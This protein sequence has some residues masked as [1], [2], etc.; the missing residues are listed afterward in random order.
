MA[1]TSKI[2]TVINLLA[3]IAPLLTA[4][5]VFPGQILGANEPPLHYTAPVTMKGG[6]GS[7]YLEIAVDTLHYHRENA[8][9]FTSVDVHA[10]FQLPFAV[11]DEVTKV[12]FVGKNI[13]LSGEKGTSNIMLDTHGKDYEKYPIIEKKA[14]LVLNKE[15]FVSIDC[16]GF[17]EMRLVG[18]FEFDPKTI[19]PA[20]TTKGDT[21]M[22]AAFD[23]TVADLE[24]IVIETGFKR[25]FK[26]KGTGD[27][28]YTV[29]GV[30]ADM[31]TVRNAD[32]FSFPKGYVQPFEKED[33]D[34]WT[35][36]ALK[37]LKVD[38]KD[39]IPFLDSLAAYNMLIDETGFS[40]WFSAGFS[41]SNN[42]AP[43]DVDQT[44][45]MKTNEKEEGQ[46]SSFIDAKLRKIAVGI[47]SNKV[48]GGELDGSLK[49]MGLKKENTEPLSVTLKGSIYTDEKSNL[50][51]SFKSTFDKS[52]TYQ[53]PVCEKASITIGAGTSVEYRKRISADSTH[54]LKGFYFNLCGSADFKSSLVELEGLKFQNLQFSTTKPYFGGGT[55]SL[56]SLKPMSLGGL[57]IGL[58][59]LSAGYD[60]ASMV[61]QLHA[62]AMLQLISDGNGAG[63]KAKFHLL[64]D[65]K[66]NWKILGLHVDS[67]AVNVDFS[68]FHLNG[69]IAIYKDD[70]VFGNGFEG[71]LTLSIEAININVA[72]AAKFGRTSYNSKNDKSYRYWYAYAQV[73]LPSGVM[74]FPP[75]VMLQ[76]VSLAVYSKMAYTQDHANFELNRVY[77]PNK[78][79]AFGFIGGIGVCVPTDNLIT[80]KV[81]LGM[82]FS[83][84]GGIKFVRLD[85]AVYML[86]SNQKNSMI[87]GTLACYYDFEN[88]ILDM[89]ADVRADLKGVITGNAFMNLHTDPDQWYFNLGTIDKPSNLKFAGIAHAKSYFMMGDNVPAFLPPLDKKITEQFNVVQS[90]AT[91]NDNS[92]MFSTGSGFAF[93]LAMALDCGLNKFI[94]ANVTLMGGTDALVVRLPSEICG[95]TKY[96]GKGRAY[97]YLDMDAGVS[98]R[99]K[100]FCIL[101]VSALASLEAEFPKPY[102]VEGK[103]CF[104]YRVLG[105]LVKGNANT[106][107]KA[108]SRCNQFNGVTNYEVTEAQFDFSG[109]EDEWEDAANKLDSATD[110]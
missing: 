95:S 35:G 100:K 110:E 105:G 92:K 73:G 67:I 49:V 101:G 83:A 4:L 52:Q 74:I 25:P 104:T 1:K 108:G 11:S 23:I 109:Y 70:A 106:K 8:G 57:S 20:D 51:Y 56:T 30:V 47:I 66:N 93:G 87:N 31:S 89:S 32:G 86:A 17:K 39:E 50:S 78:D 37:T 80:A 63:V 12:G 54:Y 76:S 46:G 85:G 91:A 62:G 26:V 55:F 59:N 71:N 43:T 65:V 3:R 9:G 29:T 88:D 15:S 99:R 33:A 69:A 77:V 64:S 45:A 72:A 98:V 13:V 34:Y 97:V 40:G 5:L 61:A 27:I 84:S 36:F 38:L 60:T 19:F 68:A 107:F 14:W 53:L 21:T 58:T 42:P 48:I 16:N 79:V 94:Y 18:E 22:K 75:A 90:E 102:Y 103:V 41:Y 10:D 7:T 28:T 2:T 44:I 96:R 82:E 6:W 81:W 24:D